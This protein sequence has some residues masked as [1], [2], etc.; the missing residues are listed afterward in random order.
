MLEVKEAKVEEK[1]PKELKEPEDIEKEEVEEKQPDKYEVKARDM[2]WVPEEDYAG[3]VD[4]WIDAKEFVK[5]APL[6]K[7]IA[8]KRTHIKNLETQMADQKKVM[9][10]LATHINEVDDIAR[11]RAIRELKKDYKA[12]LLEEDDTKAS[13]IDKEMDKLREKTPAPE[14]AELPEETPEYRVWLDKNEWYGQDTD[15]KAF[16][17]TYGL[18]LA[19]KGIYGDAMLVKVSDAV[20]R[21]FPDKFTNP[22]RS[23]APAVEGVTNTTKGKGKFS[24]SDLSSE[25][26]KVHDAFVDSGMDSQKYLKQVADRKAMKGN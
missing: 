8:E 6:F 13:E 26:K 22:R 25:E 3:D 17:D 9:K 20:K 12:A 21:Q 19:G 15:M 11:E 23:E 1:E 2:G 16:A 4:E 10:E 14:I 24:R 7:N 18:G 5:R